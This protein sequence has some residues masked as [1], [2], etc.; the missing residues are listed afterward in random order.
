M[1]QCEVIT[2]AEVINAAQQTGAVWG[3]KKSGALLGAQPA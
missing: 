1:Y 2:L 3:K